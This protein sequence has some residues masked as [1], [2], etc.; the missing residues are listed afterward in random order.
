M[1]NYLYLLNYVYI[2]FVVFITDTYT[3]RFITYRFYEEYLLFFNLYKYIQYIKKIL[4]RCRSAHDVHNKK[5]PRNLK[6]YESPTKRRGSFEK[7]SKVMGEEVEEF[8][9]E[10]ASTP[11]PIL[12]TM[13]RTSSFN[14]QLTHAGYVSTMVSVQTQPDDHHNTSPT[15]LACDNNK[16]QHDQQEPT[17]GV[18][19][20]GLLP[21]FS[22][23]DDSST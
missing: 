23:F 12:Q 20:I 4:N 18:K 17:G 1:S 15:L 13:S 8:L 21:S 14:K 11:K 22:R 9:I 3:H 19:N 5:S 6:D 16:Q 10:E 7:I 2:F